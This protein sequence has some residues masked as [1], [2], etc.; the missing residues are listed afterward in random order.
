MNM[1]WS[2][3]D[4]FLTVRLALAWLICAPVMAQQ[5]GEE[6]LY[7]G[8]DFA[9]LDTFESLNLE[10]A[11][12][13]YGKQ[14]FTGAYAAYKAYSF[15]FAKS[16]ALPY[17]LLRMGRCLHRLD[18]RNEAVKSYQDVVDYFPDSA[19]Y[20]AA[21]LYHI[22]EC[23]GQNGDDEKKTAVWARMVKDDGYV[24]QPNSGTALTYLGR[25]M[26]ELG[27]FEEAIEYHRR[28]AIA[29]LQSNP[30]AAQAA[31]ESVTY[32]YVVRGPSHEKLREFYTAASGFNGNGGD[33]GNPQDDPRYWHTVM[34]TALGANI[35]PE[36]RGAVCAYWTAKMGDR[37]TDNDGLRIQ[38]FRALLAHEKDRAKWVARMEKQ[39]A[40]KPAGVGRLVQWCGEFREL[41]RGDVKMRSEFY[42][43]YSPPLLG[44]LKL[45]DK[46]DLMEQ[47]RRHEMND[48]A[49]A[50]MRSAGPQATSDEEIRA[51]AF[52]AANYLGEEDV[53]RIL[54]RIKDPSFA[55]KSRFDYY[56]ARTWQNRPFQEKALAEIPAL[57]KDP[58]YAG[59][60]LSWAEADLLR[61]LGRLEEAIKAYQAANRQPDSTWAVTDCLV[62]LKQY[63]QAIRNVQG[64]ESVGGAVAAQACLKVADIHRT[65]GDKAKEVDQLK[66][67]LRRYPKSGESSHAHQ[68][69]ESYGVKMLGGEAKAEE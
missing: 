49:Q 12:K 38:W 42:A 37:F 2:R 5:A 26:E 68:R 27:R 67:V 19:R 8:S 51:Y 57:R 60:A 36:E 18:K 25:R 69:L 40:Q 48:E 43:K 24:G 59:P 33:V 6:I 21:A 46:M 58:K 34:A 65:G 47:L 1:S 63:D 62:A 20:A 53:L 45:S 35:K 66:L 22:G 16:P 9:K 3:R 15:E 7:P 23:H 56:S 54:A 32:H 4:N 28:T 14:D 30:R 10:D 29:F 41:D 17:V 52:F 55:A 13:L 64:L 11:D 44:G 39:F 50:V 61:M 31:R